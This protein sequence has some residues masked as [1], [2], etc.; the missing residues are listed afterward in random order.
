[1]NAQKSYILLVIFVA[2]LIGL[3]FFNKYRVAPSMKLDSL[4]LVDETGKEFRLS[5]TA[6][7]KRIISFYASWC[8]DCLREFKAL[9]T[10]KE[11][12][13]GD[14]DVIAITDEPIEKMISFKEKK[15]YPFQFLKLRKAFSDIQIFSIPV[16]YI[17][18]EK[19]ETVYEHV[20]FV[21]WTDPSTLN[22]LKTLLH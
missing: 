19:N 3:Y 11:K 13:L 14:V 7:K 22:Y 6:G 21:D 16:V 1:M 5:A 10:I 12:E 20:G 15:Q 9:N 18:N 2:G 8:G 17:V 4:E